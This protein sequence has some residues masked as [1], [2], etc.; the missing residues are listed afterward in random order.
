MTILGNVRYYRGKCLDT[1]SITL[2]TLDTPR[3]S[4]SKKNTRPLWRVGARGKHIEITDTHSAIWHIYY[5][6]K[7]FE[8]KL[9]RH[10]R[11]SPFRVKAEWGFLFGRKLLT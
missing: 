10:K 5:W 9:V 11:P 7:F 4:T 3:F 8:W 6:P 2:T 1:T